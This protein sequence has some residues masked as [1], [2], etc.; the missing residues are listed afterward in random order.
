M[1]LPAVAAKIAKP[2]NFGSDME[3]E[4]DE[5]SDSDED[6]GPDVEDGESDSGDVLPIEVNPTKAAELE[7]KSAWLSLSPAEADLEMNF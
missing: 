6:S 2:L 1:I 3:M 7:M 4:N 5:E